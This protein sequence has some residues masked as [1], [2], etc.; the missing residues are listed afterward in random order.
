MKNKSYVSQF[1]GPLPKEPDFYAPKDRE[2][3]AA[4]NYQDTLGLITKQDR[5]SLSKS[6][7]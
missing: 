2:S 3:L 1:I 5:E 7:K 6:K 4:M